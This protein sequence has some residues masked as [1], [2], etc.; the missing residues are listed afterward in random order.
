MIKNIIFDLGNVLLNFKPEEFLLRYT[1]DGKLIKKFISKVI[2]SRIWLKLDRGT[3]SVQKAREEF[4]SRFPEDSH[5]IISYFDHWMEMLTPIQNNV[6]ILR[7]LKM[8]GYKLYILSN[9]IEEAFNYV[10]NKYDFFSLFD[11]GII[12]C[13]I[14]IIKPEIEIF[15]KIIEKF[16]LDPEECLFIDDVAT[17]LFK[18]RKFKI[19]TIQYLPYTDLREELRNL[20]IDV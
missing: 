15:K 6:R 1:Q 3:L 19:K 14:H 10:C 11:G 16:N 12:S 13:R 18:A 20:N 17:F 5:L 2:R 4:L 8:K 9:F 7:D